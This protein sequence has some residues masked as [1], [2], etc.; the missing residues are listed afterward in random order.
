MAC[1]PRRS[2]RLAGQPPESFPSPVFRRCRKGED[3][4]APTV[5]WRG[6]GDA[7]EVSTA[8]DAST[9][10][11]APTATRPK[12]PRRWKRGVFLSF[13]M[14]NE[15]ADDKAEDGDGNDLFFF[16]V[17]GDLASM[18]TAAATLG[19]GADGDG[20][21]G[22]DAEDLETVSC[23]SD[24]EDLEDGSGD[25]EDLETVSYES[26]HEGVDSSNDLVLA[27]YALYL[28]GL[29]SLDDDG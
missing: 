6:G 12:R 16:D 26:D 14:D 3:A 27:M 5:K 4:A 8:S 13:E 9:S 20:N 11:V 24:H 18:S 19:N 10:E 22:G 7:P 28:K 17:V 23:E 25:A 21:D 2:P 15:L 1:R 29:N